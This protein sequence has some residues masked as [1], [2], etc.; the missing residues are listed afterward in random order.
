VYAAKH[1]ETA[2]DGDG[3][4]SPFAASLVKRMS[5]PGIEVRRLFDLVRD[6]VLALTDRH[7]QPFSYGSLPGNEDFFFV[8]KSSEA[9]SQVPPVKLQTVFPQQRGVWPEPHH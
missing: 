2:L 7:Q 4:N 5:T 1:G 8:P 9:N 3:P 6:D